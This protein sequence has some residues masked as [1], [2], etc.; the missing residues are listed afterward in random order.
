MKKFNIYDFDKTIY[1]GDSSIDFY[2]FCLK[3]NPHL[4]FLLPYISIYFIMYKLRIVEKKKFKE[5]FFS[6]LKYM[7][8]I[9][10]V[11]ELF[12]RKNEVKIKKWFIDD[13]SKNKIIISASPEFLLKPICYKLGKIELIASIVDKKN[14]KFISNNCYGEE[15]VIR[16]NERYDNYV[17]DNFYSDSKSDIYLARIAK[18]SYLVNKNNIIKWEITRKED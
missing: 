11:V 6:I 3:M 2:L 15:K 7:K 4:V 10:K 18:N 9:D 17:I 13:D 5:E 8:D 16:L 14:G 1:D 12:W